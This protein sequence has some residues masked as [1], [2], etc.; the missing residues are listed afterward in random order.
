MA[1]PAD[2]LA[3]AGDEETRAG[4]RIIRVP[5]PG[6]LRRA[7]LRSG[8][9]SPPPGLRSRQV[10]RAA[11]PASERAPGR[12]W[13]GG[14]RG[15]PSRRAVAGRRPDGG[16]RGPA[17][18][19]APWR[20]GVVRRGGRSEPAGRRVAC[21]RPGHAPA[22]D[23]AR[24]RQGGSLVYDTHEVFLEAGS[25]ARRPRWARR[26]MAAYERRLARR[27]DLVLTVNDSLADLLA[28][29]WESC[30]PRSCATA[31]RPGPRRTR[32]PTCCARR[33]PCRRA[34]RSCCTTAASWPTGACPS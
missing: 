21:P 15:G 24:R 20:G 34:R 18:A 29:R 4:V 16:R 3:A 32:R 17:R 6:R 31:R 10:P 8:G 9:G 5:I 30:A 27:A 2:L 13:W 7:L 12:R 14:R 28:Q 1:R 26:V 33:W 25:N 19:L 23:R 11:G 22:A